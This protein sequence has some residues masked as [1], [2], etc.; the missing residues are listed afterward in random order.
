M[1]ILYL[2]N[3]RFG[4]HTRPGSADL[5][6]YDAARDKNSVKGSAHHLLLHPFLRHITNALFVSHA[7]STATCPTPVTPTRL[8]CS[9]S[10]VAAPTCHAQP[11]D[12][13][14]ALR[15]GTANAPWIHTSAELQAY[16]NA[17]RSHHAVLLRAVA[18][19]KQA[20]VQPPP[21][22]PD[23]STAAGRG[24]PA[25]DLPRLRAAVA[26]RQHAMLAALAAVRHAR[27]HI[28]QQ[29]RTGRYDTP[30]AAGGVTCGQRRGIVRPGVAA[31]C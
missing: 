14:T 23:G 22:C 12:P 8:C 25:A 19:G 29:V 18:E 15:V 5:R 24:A 3:G 21:R 7:A 1:N 11:T 4:S 30:G 28:A 16:E 26:A 17:L 27:G 6:P 10:G 2:E 20:P 31:S 9:R 13:Q